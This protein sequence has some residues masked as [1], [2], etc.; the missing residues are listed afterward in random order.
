MSE[1]SA[2]DVLAPVSAHHVTQNGFWPVR[3]LVEQGNKACAVGMPLQFP[4]YGIGY[5]VP[6]CCCPQQI[7]QEHAGRA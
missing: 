6:A 3:A 5:V 2:L 7:F 4:S 1:L